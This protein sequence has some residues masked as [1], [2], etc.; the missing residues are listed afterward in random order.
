M[1]QKTIIR[2]FFAIVFVT[3][4]SCQTNKKASN[5]KVQNIQKVNIGTTNEIPLMVSNH[6]YLTEEDIGKT[7]SIGGKLS[8]ENSKWVLSENPTSKSKVTFILEVPSSL[9]KLFEENNNKIVTVK[10]KLTKVESAWKKHL[11]VESLE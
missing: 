6:S 7:F 2:I 4:I 9:E 1:K 8:G 10:G 11:L 3:C 5:E